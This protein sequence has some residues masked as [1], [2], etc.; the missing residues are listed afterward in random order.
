MR[1]TYARELLRKRW[2][3]PVALCLMLVLLCFMNAR[4]GAYAVY[5]NTSARK[6]PIYSVERD[7]KKIAISFDCAWG[8][9][10]TQGLLD[11]MREYNVKCTFFMTAFWVEKYP[12]TVKAIFD[13]GHDIGTHSVTHS[14]MSKMSVSEIESE[15]KESSALIEKITGEK[16]TLFRPPYGDYNDRLIETCEKGGFYAIQWDV[17]SL[18]WKDVTSSD[19]AKRI[20]SKTGRGSIILCH[21]NAE[22]TLEALPLVFT[23]LIGRGYEF[24]PISELIYLDNYTVDHLGRQR[25][26]RV[27]SAA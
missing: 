11:V 1:I 16:V 7:D 14:Y 26:A 19:I 24:V 27:D 12:E 13:E 10:K 22:H 17:D 23:D 8:A 6:L 15:L 3:L 21:N 4:T 9:E 2:V 20:I 25:R 5:Y 18:D